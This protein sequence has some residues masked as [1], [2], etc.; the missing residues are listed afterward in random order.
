MNPTTEPPAAIKQFVLAGGQMDVDT[1]FGLIDWLMT[2]APDWARSLDSPALPADRAEALADSGIKELEH[3]TLPMVRNRLTEMTLALGA[4]GQVRPATDDERAKVLAAV[5]VPAV[6]RA[7]PTRVTNRLD[8]WRGRAE[9]ASEP[10]CVTADG[11][12]FWLVLNPD[13]DRVILVK[14]GAV[15]SHP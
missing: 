7:F 11:K 6:G 8:V 14:A 12:T 15:R 9:Q 3:V 5:Q 2:H 13:K 10:W 4:G 1:M